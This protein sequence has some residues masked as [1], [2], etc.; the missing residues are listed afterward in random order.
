[1]LEGNR[2]VTRKKYVERIIVSFLTYTV[3][4]YI[5]VKVIF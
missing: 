1:M 2:T 3:K 5:L 4:Q